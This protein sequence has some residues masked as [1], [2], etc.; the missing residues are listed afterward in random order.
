MMAILSHPLTY[1]DLKQE[2]A[3]T[4]DQLELIE[5]EI[6]VTPAP[7][8]LHQRIAGRLYSLFNQA[9]PEQVYFAP[10]DVQLSEFSIVQPDLVVV[11]SRIEANVKAARIEGAP[12]IVAEIVSPSTSARDTVTKRDLYAR[13]DVPEYWLVDPLA[14]RVT[15]YSR[16]EGGP[17]Q[18]EQTSEDVA[19]SATIGELSADLARL[20]ARV[21]GQLERS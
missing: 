2:R 15:I 9:L 12:S 20:F 6:V 3:V 14:R 18:V 7:T 8:P 4:R 5:G 16:P 13:H 11:L 19:V 1:A 21:P 17:Y 10:V